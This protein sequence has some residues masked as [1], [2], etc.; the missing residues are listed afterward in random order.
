LSENFA[1]QNFCNHI[2]NWMKTRLL[3][4]MCP[5]ASKHYI[6]MWRTMAI[7][8]LAKNNAILSD[9]HHQCS[10][11]HGINTHARMDTHIHSLSCCNI[12]K[13][14]ERM[15]SIAK[16]R[17]C[18]RKKGATTRAARVF[19]QYLDNYRVDAADSICQIAVF[20]D[21]QHSHSTERMHIVCHWLSARYN[22]RSTEWIPSERG[23]AFAMV[24][25]WWWWLMAVQCAHTASA[26]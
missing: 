17:A 21:G 5:A 23:A 15:C 14:S 20:V 12:T 1:T 11:K 26:I 10:G 7:V 24:C 22:G 25:V 2:T 16:A 4:L 13:P 9:F 18:G 19:V 6:H 3:S 8:S